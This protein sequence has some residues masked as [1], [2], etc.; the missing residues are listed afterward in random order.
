MMMRMSW[1]PAISVESSP[2]TL[3]V[4]TISAM[5]AGAMASTMVGT[6]YPLSHAIAA[7]NSAIEPAV[8]STTTHEAHSRRNSRVR[9]SG[10]NWAPS[11]LPMRTC[12]AIRRISGM[13]PSS[14]PRWLAA[15]AMK[16]GAMSQALG[17]RV[18]ESKVATM[19][20]TTTRPRIGSHGT[21][22]MASSGFWAPNALEHQ[23]QSVSQRHR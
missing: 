13:R 22:G 11:A 10:L 15:A 5:P 3:P 16:S 1:N 20:D 6:G 19:P 12:A 18:R 7:A 2:S 17:E 23:N 9:N 14:Q 8:N 21:T 4:S